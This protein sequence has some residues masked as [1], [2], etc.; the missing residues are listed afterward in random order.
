MHPFWRIY[1]NAFTLSLIGFGALLCAGAFEPTSGPVQQLLAILGPAG[2]DA[3]HPVL[4]FSLGLM[5][6]IT[7]GWAI[8]LHGVI[9]FALAHGREA[10]PLWLA[11]IFGL[12]GWYVI[13]GICSVATGFA[14][15]LIPNTILAVMFGV[16]IVGSGVL[17]R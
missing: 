15:N 4:R 17:K 6:A 7:I 8:T 5:G 16:G 1:F 13:D 9:R 14:L 3:F 12:T 10:R 2:P 11:M